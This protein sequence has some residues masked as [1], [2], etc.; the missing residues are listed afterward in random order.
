MG[1]RSRFVRSFV[2]LT[3]E[4][5]HT[6]EMDCAAPLKQPEFSDSP[7][8]SVKGTDRKAR[9]AALANSV[10]TWE[11]DLTHVNLK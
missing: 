8:P 2:C 11:D 7:T 4:G 10:N 1:I 3:G 5:E 9:L 6:S